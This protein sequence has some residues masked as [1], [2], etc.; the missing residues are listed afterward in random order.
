[1]NEK[2]CSLKEAAIVDPVEPEKVLAAVEDEGVKL[3]TLLTTHHH[4]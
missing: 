4:W 2:N 3:T 1:V